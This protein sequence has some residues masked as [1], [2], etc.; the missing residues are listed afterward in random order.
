MSNLNEKEY[1][2]KIRLDREALI[3]ALPEIIKQQIE[4]LNGAIKL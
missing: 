2:E 1:I 4:V 3:N